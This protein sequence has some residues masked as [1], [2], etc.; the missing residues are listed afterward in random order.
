MI[1]LTAAEVA[2]IVQGELRGSGDALVTGEAQTDSRLVGDG[3]VFF[4]LP[5]ETTDGARFAS[6]AAS[7]GAT[8]VVA[9]QPI[10]LDV[11][12][13]LVADALA[14]LG[15]LARAVVARV[16]SQGDLRVVAVTGSNGK[17]TT[18]NMLRDI[19][20]TAGETVA[21]E[22]SFNNEVGAPVTMLRVRPSTRFLIAELGADAVG[23]IEKLARLAP[24]D[25]GIVLKVGTAHIG[26]F[27]SQE[28]IAIAKGELV[29]D[30]PGEATAVLN[31][32]DPRVAGMPTAARVRRFGLRDGAPDPE[33]WLA[34]GIRVTLDGTAFTLLH[35][36]DHREVRLRILGE[37]HVM[38]ALAAIAA[39]D[40]VGVG[41]ERS[42]PALEAMV[43]A[44]QWRMEVLEAPDGV[45]VINDAYNASPESMAAALR[46]LAELTRDQTP[47]RRAIAVLGEMA[48][49]G[50]H[51]TEAHDRIGRLAVRLNIDRLVVVGERA[52][53]M[54]LGAQHE[55]SWGEE[56]LF[57]ETNEAA[58]DA[59]R[60]LLRAGDVVLVKSSKSA[61][62]RHVG[63]RIAGRTNAEGATS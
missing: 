18:K 51:A 17:T 39:A 50:P 36:G 27:G 49:L 24:P 38:N 44:E 60:A 29:R 41:P 2:D 23:D 54:H 8:L 28:R 40:A 5:G 46:S 7:A 61:G 57:V 14:A 13:V 48:E 10:E 9:Q 63:D 53:A 12:V 42:V 62:L 32:D 47:S 43:R 45:V 31:R 33:D 35:G 22:G 4:A 20:S 55:G 16:R 37:H 15:E 19:L 1:R 26:K 6:A 52:R 30:L 25:V 11:P 59:V 56:A 21:P 3:D 58:Y 34:D